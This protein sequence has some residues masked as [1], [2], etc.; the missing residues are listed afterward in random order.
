MLRRTAMKSICEWELTQRF[1]H[2]QRHC[3]AETV[4]T[5]NHIFNIKTKCTSYPP[6]PP[7]AIAPSGP[8]PPHSRGTPQS[9]GLIWTS[10]QLVAETSTWQHTTQQTNFHASGGIRTH[11][12]SRRAAADLRLRP[13]GHWDRQLNS[14]TVQYLYYYI[15]N[16]SYMFRRIPHH[17]QEELFLPC[18]KLSA[19]CSIVTLATMRKIH[20]MWVLQRYLQL[21]GGLGSVV[22]KALG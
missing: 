14:H 21:L 8:W 1:L 5:S 12:L 18:S 19:Y 10:D 13:R 17:P 9:V 4:L 20:H 7:G 16:V 15:S 22:V 3:W 2:V 6:T 11:N